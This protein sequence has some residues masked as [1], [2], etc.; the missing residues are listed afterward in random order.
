MQHFPDLFI[1]INCCTCFR[2]LLRLS[3]GAQNCTYSVRCCHTLIKDLNKL[4]VNVYKRS[5]GMIQQKQPTRC[6]LK[7]E[8]I[9][10]PLIKGLTCFERYAAH[11]QELQLYLQPLVYIRLWRPA[12][13]RSEWE[14]SESYSDF[15]HIC[16]NLRSFIQIY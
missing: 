9:I 12:V 13:V 4:L 15:K 3:S 11:H 1:Y 5:Q 10:P 14:L 7:T 16:F 6:N 2:R 8:F